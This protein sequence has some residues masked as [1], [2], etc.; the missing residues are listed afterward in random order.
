LKKKFGFADNIEITI[1]AN[2][3]NITKE[4][5]KWWKKL[6]VNRISIWV[7]TLNEKALKEV[8]RTWKWDIFEALDILEKEQGIDVSLDF[9]IGLPFVK[10][11]E[12]KENIEIILSKYPFVSHISVYMLEDYKTDF[13]PEEFLEE[14]LWIKTFLESKDFE[15]YELSNFS[16]PWKKCKHNLGYWH[17]K[18]CLAFGLWAHSFIWNTRFANSNKFEEYYV[19]KG[20]IEEVL[21]EEELFLEKIMF[22]LR[23]NWIESQGTKKLNNEKIKEFLENWYLVKAWDRVYL[24]D[25]WVLLLDYI[26]KEII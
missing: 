3:E 9:I 22:A 6:W 20:K 23:T 24:A 12:I 2:P 16:K 8:W 21:S 10:R 5:L 17:H 14:Y 13:S 25:K 11:W 26:L 7:Q 19:S 1:E 4:N 18:T 15:R